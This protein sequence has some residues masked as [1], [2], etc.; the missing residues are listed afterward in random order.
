MS[1]GRTCTRTPDCTT[2]S[3]PSPS[4]CKDTDNERMAAIVG[5]AAGRRLTY[6]QAA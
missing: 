5:R 3:L 2:A 1:P 6:Q 4:P